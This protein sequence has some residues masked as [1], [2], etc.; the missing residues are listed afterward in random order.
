MEIE[1]LDGGGFLGQLQ[2]GRGQGVAGGFVGGAADQI[3]RIVANCEQLQ[4]FIKAAPA[5]QPD[6]QP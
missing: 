2:R 3:A 4:A 5:N 6:A 1:R